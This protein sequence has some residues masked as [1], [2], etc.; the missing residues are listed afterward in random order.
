VALARSTP[1]NDN[2]SPAELRSR[3]GTA[4][5]P[6]PTRIWRF[7]RFAA[8]L[9]A[10]PRRV[11]RMELLGQIA[12][13]RL[14]RLLEGLTYLIAIFGVPVAI[15]L[16][17][18]DLEAAREQR[19]WEIYES[20]QEKYLEFISAA[21]AQPRVGVVWSEEVVPRE[22]LPPAERVTQDLLF[23]LLCSVFERA[24]IVY[25]RAQDGQRRQQ[26]AGWLGWIDEYAGR[27]NFRAWWTAYSES[28]FPS[29]QYDTAFEEFMDRRIADLEAQR[30]RDPVPRR[31]P[32]VPERAPPT[33]PE[34]T[35]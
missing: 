6:P 20:V 8:Y 30:G 15:F 13:E 1:S 11:W 5:A 31:P 9:C 24:F 23:D 22:A 28:G 18:R 27:R 21:L 2:T 17:R 14:V 12:D 26:W 35:P 34:P 19:E 32:L 10:A 25:Q 3:V 16:Y 4:E 29:N 33:S 7:V